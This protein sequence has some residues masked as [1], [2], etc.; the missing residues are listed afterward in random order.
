MDRRS[1][2]AVVLSIAV[3]LIFQMFFLPKR[4]PQPPMAGRDSAGVSAPMA[5]GGSSQQTLS[6]PGS[7]P[8]QSPSGLGPAFETAETEEREIRVQT[9]LYEAVFT[10]LGARL[11]SW[12]LKPYADPVGQWVQL[13]PPSEGQLGLTV[14]TDQGPVDLRRTLFSARQES[15]SDGGKRIRFEARSGSAT[16]TKVFELPPTGYLI[17]AQV[18]IEGLTD[19]ESYRIGWTGGIPRAERN[20]K[21]YHTALAA[22]VLKGK[23][24]ENVHP[25]SFKNQ[26]EKLV[27]GNIRWAG[28]RNKYFMA[29]IIPPESSSN[30]VVVTG[31]NEP[32][33]VGAEI[34]MPVSGGDARH[35]FRVYLGPMDYEMLKAQGYSLESAV[36]LGFKIF[37]PVAQL[38]QTVM[39]WMYRYIPNYGVVIIIVSVLTKVIFYPLTRSSLKSMR[40]MQ[41]LQP[42]MTALRE[43]YKKDNARLQQEMMGLYKKHGVNPVGGCLPIFLQMPV[44]I[45]LYQVLANSIAMRSAP[46]FGWM[47][48]LSSPDTIATLGGFDIHVL[49]IILFGF[50][51]L[52]QVWTPVGD[53]R[54]KMIGYMMPLVTLFIFYGFPAGLNLY[55][56][57]NSVVTVAQQWVIHRE[58]PATHPLP[59]KA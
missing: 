19:A 11:L 36:D 30:R 10:N 32:K 29:V 1:V 42:E 24:K 8:Y 34:V 55:W 9:D 4:E 17:D 44:F 12:R 58:D 31:S 57:I 21:A 56:T 5:T 37:R 15:R 45:A 50:T 43:K 39:F 28:V 35:L 18:Q 3:I 26:S 27:E 14:Q 49:P 46:F 25:G 47:H 53:P 40:A 13:V 59:V 20:E 23:N 22:M 54:Q 41:R 48:D 51:V 6:E 38:L 2:L 16:V 7:T 33:R 52:Q